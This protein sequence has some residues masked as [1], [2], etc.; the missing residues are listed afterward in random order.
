MPEKE[1][2]DIERGTEPQRSRRTS[3]S[4]EKAMSCGFE[5]ISSVSGSGFLILRE[6]TVSVCRHVVLTQNPASHFLCRFISYFCCYGSGVISRCERL[7]LWP[8]HY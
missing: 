2:D 8:I 1:R 7:F 6:D 3:S 4:E 5:P